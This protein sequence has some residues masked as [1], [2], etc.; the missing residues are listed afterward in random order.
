MG[1]FSAKSWIS[2]LQSGPPVIKK[3]ISGIAIGLFL[4]YVNFHLT[5]IVNDVTKGKTGLDFPN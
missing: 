2:V 3:F 5:Y 1:H 4:I